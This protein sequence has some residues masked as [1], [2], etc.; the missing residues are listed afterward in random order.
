ML[1]IVIHFL[2]YEKVKSFHDA[3]TIIEIFF[4]GM[5]QDILISVNNINYD[6]HTAAELKSVAV[7]GILTISQ[8]S[9][10]ELNDV[11]LQISKIINNMFRPTSERNKILLA[12]DEFYYI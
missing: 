1:D 12:K 2:R 7:N 9:I 8:S 11:D 10:F 6:P 5:V 3:L 4:W